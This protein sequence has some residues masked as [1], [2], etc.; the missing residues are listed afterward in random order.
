MC[1]VTRQA[2]ACPQHTSSPSQ[3]EKLG[4]VPKW[5]IP[6]VGLSFPTWSKRELDKL[7]LNTLLNRQLTHHSS[8]FQALASCRQEP[9]ASHLILHSLPAISLLHSGPAPS[10]CTASSHHFPI[11]IWL[12][13]HSAM[14]FIYPGGNQAQ[15]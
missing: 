10:P 14:A 9:V 11:A 1:S 8:H 15:F 6:C 12:A 13:S 2:S 3:S 7:T 4:S 5:G